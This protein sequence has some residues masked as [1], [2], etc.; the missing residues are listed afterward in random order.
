MQ[1]HDAGDRADST[2]GL[3]RSWGPLP[4][5]VTAAFSAHAPVCSFVVN[6][7]IKAD[8][9]AA[10]QVGVV[11][12]AVP[13]Q[14]EKTEALLDRITDSSTFDNPRMILSTAY[15]AQLLQVSEFDTPVERKPTKAGDVRRGHRALLQ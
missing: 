11:G 7:V 6:P 12:D 9:L 4:G 13:L 3:T 10:V 2:N 1:E 14:G 15:P 8:V 5:R